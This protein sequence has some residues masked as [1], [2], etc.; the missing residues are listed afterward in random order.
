M[1]FIGDTCNCF[2]TILVVYKF[3]WI[4]ELVSLVVLYLTNPPIS[5]IYSPVLKSR[6]HVE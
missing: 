2:C 4:I 1:A 6:Y 3:W 5:Q